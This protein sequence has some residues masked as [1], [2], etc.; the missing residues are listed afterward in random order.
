[1]GDYNTTEVFGMSM[2][3]RSAQLLR[4]IMRLAYSGDCDARATRRQA[5]EKLGKLGP[6]Q[7]LS[8]IVNTLAF[9]G[10]CDAR[11]TRHRALEL[12]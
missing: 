6:T 8:Y 7:A 10:D 12:L 5:L 4:L 9:A 3:Q 2:D 1:M 11:E